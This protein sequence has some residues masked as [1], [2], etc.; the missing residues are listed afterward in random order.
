[1]SMNPQVKTEWLEALRSGEYKQGRGQLCRRTSEGDEFCCL[2]VLSEI[3]ARHGI[4]DRIETG[5]TASAGNGLTI[6]YRMPFTYAASESAYLPLAVKDWADLDENNPVVMVGAE[7]ADGLMSG[8][9]ASTLAR[10]NDDGMSFSEIAELIE[11]Q[12]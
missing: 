11:N 4:V 1:M 9:Y 6:S 3:A 2:G 8:K 7:G 12:L 5:E 10:Q